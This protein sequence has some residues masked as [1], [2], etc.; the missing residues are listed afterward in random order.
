VPSLSH[1]ALVLLFRNRPTLAEELLRDTLHVSLPKHAHVRVGEADLTEL[2]PTEYRADLVIVLEGEREHEPAGAIIV[3]PQ[4]SKDAQKRWS[5]PTYVCGLRAR[6]RCNVVLLVISIDEAVAAWARAPIETG[7]PGFTLTP[8]VV[9]PEAVPAILDVA[10]AK[11]APELAVLSAVAHGHD[12]PDRAVQIANAALATCV[13]LDREREVLYSDLVFISLSE[14]AKS[15]MEKLMA[16]GHYEPQSEF[17]RN[18]LKLRREAETGRAEGRAEGEAAA[19]LAVLETR[20]L[21]LTEEQRARIRGCTEADVLD[22]WVRKAVTVASA[23]E[24]FRE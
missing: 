15:I 18:L 11:R 23:D 17:A 1:E 14:A 12:D 22:R 3:E 24:L 5:W 16:S 13:G 9:G 7:H 4:L 19:V 20:G 21:A 6:L 8:L 10:V 2:V